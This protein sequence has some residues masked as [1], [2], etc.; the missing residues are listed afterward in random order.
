MLRHEELRAY[1]GER[2]QEQCQ[3]AE[4]RRWHPQARIEREVKLIGYAAKRMVSGDNATVCSGTVLA[5]GDDRNGFGDIRIGAESWIGQ[6][7]NLRASGNASIEV[8]R[9]PDKSILHY[10]RC[11]IMRLHG[12][13]L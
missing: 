7:N 1:L 9:V 2:W 13:G 8:V 10:C 5:F 4:V 6:Y 3:L 11:R 12:K